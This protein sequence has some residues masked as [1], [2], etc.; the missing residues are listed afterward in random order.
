MKPGLIRT[1]ALSASI[2][3]GAFVPQAFAG[4]WAIRWLVVGML[5]LVFLQTRLSREAVHRSH[6]L[7]LAANLVLGFAGWALGWLIG[8][9]DVAL[10]AF[11]AAITP[12]ATAAPVVVSFLRGRVDYVIAAF[13]VTNLS[14]AALLPVMLPIVLGRATPG[15]FVQVLGSVGLVV[16]VPMGAAWLLRAVHAGAADWPQHLRNLSFGM[17]V[18]ALFL[19]TANASH[20]I[21]SHPELPRGDL[22]RI[23]IVTA[24]LCAANFATGRAIGGRRFGRE[25]SQSLGQKNTT[26]TIYLALTYASPLVALGP[27]CYVVWHNLWNSWQL[28]RVRRHDPR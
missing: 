21:R 25:A 10:A 26:L 17:W 4:A 28:H 11:F 20:F 22:A 8:G 15:L 9:R 3:L 5:F 14:I 12:T 6:L 24:L 2:A 19:I 27:T 1:V 7:L 13:L 16:F 18:L 23:A